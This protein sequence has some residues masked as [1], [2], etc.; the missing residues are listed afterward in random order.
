MRY[1]HIRTS[2]LCDLCKAENED[3]VHALVLCSHAQSFWMVGREIMDLKLPRLHP[4]TW[5]RDIVLDSMFTSSERCKIIMIM[6][7]IWT[8]RNRWTHDQ[9]GYNTIQAVKGAR[10]DLLLLELPSVG[11][12]TSNG[13]CWCPPDPG[14]VKIN[15]DRAVDLQTLKGGKGG[16]AHCHLSFLG[17]WSKPLPGVTDPSIA[18][19]LALREGVIFAR[20]RGFSHVV[21]EL[22][23]LEVINL[24]H[25]HHNSRSTVAPI[26]DEIRE[27]ASNFASF[28]VQHAS[29]EVN[30]PADLCAKFATTL[31]IYDF[32]GWMKV[33]LSL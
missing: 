21:M 33:L 5:L 4:N 28:L 27:R 15:I 13:H 29:R 23:C 2:S 25:S 1:R 8:S 22:D 14:W 7:A 9:D 32:V 19:V 6:H 18:E 20:L 16:V 17:A 31:D 12:S 10:D 24:R 11:R 26:F 3:L 30:G